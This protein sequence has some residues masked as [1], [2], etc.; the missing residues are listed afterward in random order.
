[1]SNRKIYFEWDV[2]SSAL[3][4]GIPVGFEVHLS[5]NQ[6]FKPLNFVL[7]T[8]GETN[9]PILGTFQY[10]LNAGKT[11]VNYPTSESGM[12]FTSPFKMR[13]LIKSFDLG[14]IYALRDSVL[15]RI[16]PNGETIAEKIK[17]KIDSP[18]GINYSEKDSTILIN[19]H[20]GTLYKIN[21]KDKLSSRSNSVNLLT[22]PIS[23]VNDSFRGTFW[24]INRDRVYLKNNFGDV[25]FSVSL[26]EI[27]GEA[28]DDDFSSSSS[29][30]SEEFSSSSS[31]G[32]GIDHDAIEI[33]FRIH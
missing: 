27:Y 20:F 13:L 33:D 3:Q 23:I 8:S 18:A 14:F 24:Q 12:T 26:P 16:T 17:L 21:T 22:N 28:I 1:M 9:G 5:T 30:S 7:K 4:S 6:S 15:Y 31:G 32:I 11:W 2:P 10:S 19:S 29:S 25:L